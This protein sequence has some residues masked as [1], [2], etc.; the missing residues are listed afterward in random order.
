[1]IFFVIALT[2]GLYLFKQNEQN[3]RFEKLFEIYKMKDSVDLANLMPL[4]EEGHGKASYLLGQYYLRNGDTSQ[5]LIYFQKSFNLGEEIYGGWKISVCQGIEFQRRWWKSNYSKVIEEAEED[6]WYLPFVLGRSIMYEGQ[7]LTGSK[8]SALAFRM[9]LK[10]AEHGF[11]RAII[12]ITI[13]YHDGLGTPVNMKE[14][15]KWATKGANMG[16]V[17]SQSDLSICYMNGLGVKQSTELALKY[18]QL[19]ADKGYSDAQYLLA[20]WYYHGDGGIVVNENKSMKWAKKAA[21]NGNVSAS[22]LIEEY[23]QKKRASEIQI[24]VSQEPAHSPNYKSVPS[25]HYFTKQCPECGK[26]W[27]GMWTHGYVFRVICYSGEIVDY[28]FKKDNV[29]RYCSK[30]CAY[31]VCLRKSG[32]IICGQWQ[33]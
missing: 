17:T 5:A 18:A 13:F 32:N 28:E 2:Y 12:D 27:D 26:I 24:I 25:Q 22:R 14:V 21:A 10:S 30:D 9:M 7:S 8:D 4:V 33:N 23:E 31:R 20:Y 29:G 19:A 15:F 11:P 3:K 1:M 6:D 16:N